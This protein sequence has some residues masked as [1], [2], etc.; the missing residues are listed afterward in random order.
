MVISEVEFSDMGFLLPTCSWCEISSWSI[1]SMILL[2]YDV[3]LPF[4]WFW[5]GFYWGELL[6][7]YPYAC[8]LCHGFVWNYAHQVFDSISKPG[9]LFLCMIL[10]YGILMNHCMLYFWQNSKTKIL[11][12]HDYLSNM[13][14]WDLCLPC[15]W[16]YFWIED[17]WE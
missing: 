17:S 12:K 15:I 2:C 16:C 1:L 11:I 5:F 14:S 3:L 6:R 10:G 13:I 4:L 8:F 7:G 9:N